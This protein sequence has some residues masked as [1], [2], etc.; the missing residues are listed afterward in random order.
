MMDRETPFL[1]M[2][3]QTIPPLLQHRQQTQANRKNFNMPVFSSHPPRTRKYLCI[4]ASK[5]LNHRNRKRMSSM[6]L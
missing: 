1:Y 3:S 6:L 4:P 5:S 2:P